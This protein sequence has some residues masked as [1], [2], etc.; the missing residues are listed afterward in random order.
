[1]ALYGSQ[2]HEDKDHVVFFIVI[3]SK[4]SKNLARGGLYLSNH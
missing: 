2:A 4:F 1:M 3:A